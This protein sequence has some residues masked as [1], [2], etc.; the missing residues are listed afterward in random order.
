MP[1]LPSPAATT[2][3]LMTWNIQWGLGVPGAGGKPKAVDLRAIADLVHHFMP[4]VL[5]LQE[6][7]RYFPANTGDESDQASQLLSLL[8]AYEGYFSAATNY[9]SAE[10]VGKPRRQFGN[11]VLVKGRVLSARELALPC[12]HDA[13]IA[14]FTDRCATMVVARIQCDEHKPLDIGIINTHLEYSGTVQRTAQ[15]QALASWARDALAAAPQSRPDFPKASAVITALDRPPSPAAWVLA[16]D[17]NCAPPSPELALLAAN[18]WRDTWQVCYPALPH[19]P[20]LGVHVCLA[21]Y[22]PQN[23]DRIYVNAYLADRTVDC[24]VVSKTT[25][26]DHQPVLATFSAT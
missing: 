22:Q 13:T 3:S 15:V 4:D 10:K 20:T 12:P 1:E 18:G 25:A 24:Q 9:A 23:F 7:C 16:G 11:M 6:V 21:G 26:S 2:F 17:F 14:K 19:P 5:C 8:P